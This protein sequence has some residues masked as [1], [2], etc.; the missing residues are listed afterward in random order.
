VH[1]PGDTGATR[2]VREAGASFVLALGAAGRLL[3][4]MPPVSD[5]RLNGRFHGSTRS[6][7]MSV[8]CYTR[9]GRSLVRGQ[10]DLQTADLGAMGPQG[11]VD[12]FGLL[13]RADP[14]RQARAP[15]P[16][17]L[18]GVLEPAVAWCVVDHRYR[19]MTWGY[20]SV[21]ANAVNE[22]RAR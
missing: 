9:S 4:V 16:V 21:R 7:L 18:F 17:T 22:K 11:G 13:S 5:V 3:A 14:G 10:G 6:A 12:T 20:W 2:H 8:C 1:S 19:G 15:G